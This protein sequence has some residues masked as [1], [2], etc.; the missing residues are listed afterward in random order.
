MKFGIKVM[1]RDVILDSQGRAIEKVLKDSQYTIESCRMGKFIE[2][3]IP[4]SDES[5]A[6]LE[7]KKMVDST[8]YNP[9]IETYEVEKL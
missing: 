2:I 7:V 1:P 3:T 6:Y 8:L 9:L 5:Q 4:E